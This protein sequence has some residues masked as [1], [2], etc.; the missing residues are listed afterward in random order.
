MIVSEDAT[1][2]QIKFII[3]P[4]KMIVT[5]KNAWLEKKKKKKRYSLKRDLL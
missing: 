3:F 5:F 1:E 4:G 2:I